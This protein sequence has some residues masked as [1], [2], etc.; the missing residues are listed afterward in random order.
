S[1]LSSFVND[2]KKLSINSVITSVADV[3]DV[4]FDEQ[5]Y[6]IRKLETLANSIV[7]GTITAPVVNNESTVVEVAD[8]V[9]TIINE[10]LEEE[11]VVVKAAFD[12]IEVLY[13]DSK[14]VDVAQTTL[15][16]N[17]DKVIASVAN[18][19]GAVPSIDE[20]TRYTTVE[21]AKALAQYLVEGELQSITFNKEA[22]IG[23]TVEL[24]GDIVLNYLAYYEIK[25]I[26]EEVAKLTSDVRFTNVAEDAKAIEVSAIA[27]SV[28]EILVE[29]AKVNNAIVNTALEEVSELYEGVSVAS[30]VEASKE[31]YVREVIVSVANVVEA[32]TN[33][34]ADLIVADVEALLV[35]LLNGTVSDLEIV[36]LSIP[37]LVDK[38]EEVVENFTKDNAIVKAVFEEV[39]TLYEE[40]TITSI[41]KDSESLSIN[42][43][44]SS[45]AN[46]LEAAK[47]APEVVQAIASLA[48]EVVTGPIVAPKFDETVGTTELVRKVEGLINTI[49]PEEN[50]IISTVCNEVEKL[51][52][53]SKLV[54]IATETMS[55]DVDEVVR[56][57]KAVIASVEGM[58]EAV[59]VTSE[60]VLTLVSDVLD[61]AVGALK[62]AEDATL[63]GV[64]EQVASIVYDY[65]N[66]SEAIVE[67]IAEIVELTEEVQLVE[68]VNDLLALDI[69]KTLEAVNGLIDAIVGKDVEVL[70]TIFNIAHEGLNGALGKL[71]VNGEALWN[72]VPEERKPYIIATGAVAAVVLYFVANDVLVE[73]VA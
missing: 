22:T 25:V 57:M 70:N 53:T 58:P 5:T 39:R 49:I 44:I 26:V 47:V 43:V 4:P 45:V 35:A 34:E 31:L 10:F 56:S 21:E 27:E 61:E 3:L 19:V 72:A 33:D 24:A 62:V 40:S 28:K 15:E 60:K 36:D 7:S 68:I 54:D 2:S 50:S 16:L 30:I 37:R 73:I 63:G 42:G 14:L 29:V 51:Y 6:L 38:V 48:N 12:E 18:V 66:E 64:I 59:S 32:G 71:E 1:T 9:E 52:K 46:V 55:L 67:A 41:A 11:N 23:K 69:D 20:M 65:V 17:V 13:V 8:A